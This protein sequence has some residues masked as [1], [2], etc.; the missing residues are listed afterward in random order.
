MNIHCDEILTSLPSGV[1]HLRVRRS[2][3]LRAAL[4]RFLR[5]Q[6]VSSDNVVFAGRA[7]ERN[8]RTDEH[9][10]GKHIESMPHEEKG[11]KWVLC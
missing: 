9:G 5:L 3:L 8:S 1:G 6:T 2:A 4:D 11:G 7:H 10:D